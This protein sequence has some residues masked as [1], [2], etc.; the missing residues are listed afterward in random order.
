M[1]VEDNGTA[2]AYLV[3][4]LARLGIQ[5]VVV[6][7]AQE[8]L[9]GIERNRAVGFPLDYIFVDAGMAPPGGFQLVESW[10]ASG[11]PERLLV[12]M[13]TENQRHDSYNFV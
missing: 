9:I 11:G 3:G 8:A 1:V 2:G 5:G 6:A 13:T 4:L 7:S 12:M 10:R